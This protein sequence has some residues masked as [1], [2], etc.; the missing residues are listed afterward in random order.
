MMQSIFDKFYLG[1]LSIQEI[2]E[3]FEIYSGIAWLINLYL[4]QVYS[5]QYLLFLTKSHNCEINFISNF[6]NFWQKINF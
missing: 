6:S 1:I 5:M 3:N 4:I 2:F